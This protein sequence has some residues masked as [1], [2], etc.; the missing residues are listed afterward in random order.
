MKKL[1]LAAVAA[2]AV[3][4]FLPASALAQRHSKH[5]RRAHHHTR[6]HHKKFGTD[7]TAPTT[8]SGTTTPVNTAP[9]SLS[10]V[11]FTNNVLT[12]SDASGQQIMGTVTS[13]TRLICVTQQ[14]SNTAPSNTMPTSM[15]GSWHGHDHGGWGGGDQGGGGNDQGDDDQGQGDDEGHNQQCT[16]ADLMAGTPVL[17]ADLSLSSNGTNWDTVVLQVPPSTTAPSVPDT[18]NDGE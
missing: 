2:C 9:A 1:M 14:P 3:V 10:V 8:P 16:T 4:A 13:D 17:F 7:P 11:S 12:I 18:D 6:V 15:G 5:H